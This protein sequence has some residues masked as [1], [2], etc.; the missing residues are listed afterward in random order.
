MTL[1]PRGAINYRELFLG[2]EAQC[3]LPCWILKLLRAVDL[4][5]AFLPSSLSL[6]EGE[7]L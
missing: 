7:H 2:L 3:S 6:L 1:A 5:L 4:F